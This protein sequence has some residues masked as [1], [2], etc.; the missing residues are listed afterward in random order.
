MKLPLEGYKTIIGGGIVLLLGVF[1]V[2]KKDIQNGIMLIGFGCSILGI[3]GKLEN[4]KGG[5]K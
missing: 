4:L 1:L 5:D 3:G 2:V